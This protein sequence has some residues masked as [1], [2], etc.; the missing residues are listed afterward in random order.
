MGTFVVVISRDPQTVEHALVACAA[1][2]TEAQVVREPEEIRRWWSEAPLTLVGS[3]MAPL[4]AGLAST[5]SSSGEALGPEDVEQEPRDG[6]IE[7]HRVD[8]QA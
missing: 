6:G 5:V 2:Q 8:R 3:E 4:V 7:A 1:A